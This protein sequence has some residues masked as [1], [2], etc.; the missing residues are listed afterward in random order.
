MYDNYAINKYWHYYHRSKIMNTKERILALKL[1][2]KQKSNPKFAKK[3][4]IDIKIKK[5][6][7][8]RY[9]SNNKNN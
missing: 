6:D 1:L 2:E 7:T 3:I 8:C 4:G 9:I 5:V